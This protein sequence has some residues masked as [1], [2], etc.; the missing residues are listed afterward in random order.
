MSRAQLLFTSVLLCGG[1]LFSCASSQHTTTQPQKLV[2]RV[3]V[4]G[5]EPFTKLALKVEDGETC[6]LIGTKEIETMLL[7]H[8][9][10]VVQIFTTGV[11]ETSEGKAWR[12]IQAEFLPNK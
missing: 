11:E 2:G 8:Q 12:V 10:Q 4:I 1:W 3:F 5:N 7:Q 9:G 6:V